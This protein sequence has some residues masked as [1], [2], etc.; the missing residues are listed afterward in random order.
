[1]MT[2]DSCFA[3]RLRIDR[4]SSLAF[5]TIAC[6]SSFVILAARFDNLFETMSF[7]SGSRLFFGDK[8]PC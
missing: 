7:G 3:M 5:S 4:F 2:L 8:S 1:M 6:T